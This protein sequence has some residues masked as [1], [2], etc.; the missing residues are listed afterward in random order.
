MKFGGEVDDVL[1]LKEGWKAWGR[2]PPSTQ[3]LTRARDRYK[4]TFSDGKKTFLI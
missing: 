3:W 1:T 2:T 4:K